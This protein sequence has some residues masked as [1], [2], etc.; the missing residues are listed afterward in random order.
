MESRTDQNQLKSE[1]QQERQKKEKRF[2]I[3]KLEERI[4]P[5]LPHT[6]NGCAK[7]SYPIGGDP[8]GEW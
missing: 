4:A 6:S 3:I 5:N 1:E 8:C 7:K 2:R